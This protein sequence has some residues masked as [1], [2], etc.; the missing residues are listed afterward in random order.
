[1]AQAAQTARNPEA[2]AAAVRRLLTDAEMRRQMGIL[3]QAAVYPK[4]DINNLVRNM[5][6]IYLSL[7]RHGDPQGYAKEQMGAYG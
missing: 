3:G 1:M 2:T 5:G 6:E 7:L 4:Y